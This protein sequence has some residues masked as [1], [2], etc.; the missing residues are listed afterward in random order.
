MEVVSLKQLPSS[1]RASPLD[2]EAGCEGV[3]YTHSRDSRGRG[4]VQ[5]SST[6]Q[7]GASVAGAPCPRQA[8]AAP[9]EQDSVLQSHHRAV[10]RGGCSSHSGMPPRGH[11]LI[12]A[13]FEGGNMLA[14]SR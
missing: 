7:Q 14:A 10:E 2:D 13:D 3:G 9:W 4:F 6:K 12:H 8:G 5:G 1:S 11:L